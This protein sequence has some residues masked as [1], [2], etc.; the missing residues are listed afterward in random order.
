MK[1][2]NKYM[3]KLLAIIILSL[4]FLTSLQ[5][6]D[7][8]DFQ[9]EGIALGDSAL[10]YFSEDEIKN[11]KNYHYKNK[12][13]FVFGKHL[14]NSDNYEAIQLAIKDNDPK[15]IIE[16]L[17]GK[18]FYNDNQDECNKKRSLIVKELTKIFSK[19]IKTSID[20]NYKMKA[21]KTG[22][23]IN[24][25]SYFWFPNGDIVS[26]ECSDWSKEINYKDN[27]KVRIFSN[28]YNLF[29]INEA[30]K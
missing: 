9:I 22:K 13:Y 4:C 12:K 2:T 1:L 15:Y 18:I 3:K 24:D 17:S 8:R 6:D 29:L 14:Q 28:K 20:E 7:I 25:A 11:N 30:Y 19:N 5:A 26:V 23:S 21:D 27:L 10:D 16:N